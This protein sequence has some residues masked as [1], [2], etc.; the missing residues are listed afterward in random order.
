MAGQPAPVRQRSEARAAIEGQLPLITEFFSGT[1][2]AAQTKT[3]NVRALGPVVSAEVATAESVWQPLAQ[4]S[5]LTGEAYGFS[6]DGRTLT[7]GDATD[8]Y[9]P[10]AGTNNL[11]VTYTPRETMTRSGPQEP[12]T[13]THQAAVDAT[14]NGTVAT[15]TGYGGGTVQIVCGTITSATLVFEGTQDGTNYDLVQCFDRSGVK[16]SASSTD[17]VSGDNEMWAVDTTGLV[18]FRVRVSAIVNNGS[19]LTATGTYLAYGPSGVDTVTG[20]VQGAAAQDAAAAG[21]PLLVGLEYEALGSLAT[22]GTA[23]DVVNAKSTASGIQYIQ[24]T[25]GTNVLP[26]GDA[27]ARA[28]HA[29]VG[30]GTT[31]AVVEVAGTKKALNVNVTDGTNDMPTLDAVSRR[32]FVT[33]TDGTNEMP[34]MDLAARKGFVQLTDG[35]TSVVVNAA[36][37]ALDVNIDG[38]GGT[39]TTLGQ[40]LMAASMPVTLASDQSALATAGTDAHDAPIAG[41]PMLVGAEY[42]PQGSLSTVSTAGDVTQLK[43]DVNGR[44][45][46]APWSY[47]TATTLTWAGAQGVA[48]DVAPG[49]DT[50][51]D[52]RGA[53]NG[54]ATVQ[55]TTPTV[56]ATAPTFDL[57]VLASNDGGTVY[58]TA[59]HLVAIAAQAENVISVPIQLNVAGLTHIKCRLDINVCATG[60]GEDV[61]VTVNSIH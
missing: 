59:Y 10:A 16:G 42:E 11:R 30:D 48:N 45:Y 15:V 53:Q 26:T 54:V 5:S 23:G 9:N 3:L 31:V 24:H 58:G 35:T 55:L 44:V 36:T 43:A 25:D 22:V 33:H 39:A 50:A 29:A 52:V 12:L 4:V 56:A 21:N 28:I 17:V 2:V 7:F 18:S 32:G 34:T 1:G 47:A 20:E 46:Q 6:F 57:S 49:T 19:T 27:V 13:V 61:T 37:A 40:K 14:G 60:V 8:G 38:Y 41:K 51:H